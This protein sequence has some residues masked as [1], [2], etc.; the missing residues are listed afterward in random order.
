ME[1][2]V[3]TENK[4]AEISKGK[5]ITSYPNEWYKEVE[6]QDYYII[7]A[8]E[9]F[10][11]TVL[12]DQEKRWWCAV[13]TDEEVV[14]LS[15]TKMGRFPH[16]L[17]AGKKT[18]RLMGGLLVDGVDMDTP[19]AKKIGWLDFT[20]NLGSRSGLFLKSK[21]NIAIEILNKHGMKFDKV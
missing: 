1:Y 2:K 15:V 17:V 3:V 5:A 8:D 6:G 20:G 19:L 21:V 12:S 11:T 18:H 7:P 9:T 16:E 13:N 10:K 4:F 14:E